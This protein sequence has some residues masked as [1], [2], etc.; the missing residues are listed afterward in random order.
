MA[1][2]LIVADDLTGAL[3]SAVPF[4]NRRGRVLVART[5]A[6][7]PAALASGAEVVS[8]STG[9][10]DGS[11]EA[12]RKALHEV[13]QAIRNEPAILF[14]KIDS[15]LKGHIQAELDTLLHGY[16]AL[17]VSPALPA[18]GRLCIDRRVTGAGVETPIP[19]AERIGRPATIPEI[20]SDADLDAALPGDLAGCVYVGAAGLAAA[21]ARRLRPNRPAPPDL[22][23]PGPALLAI[24][25]RDPVTGAQVAMLRQIPVHDAPNGEA[26]DLPRAP[27][28]L[29]RMT[30]GS[31]PAEPGIAGA[32]FAR[33]AL[34][35]LV[36]LSA[37]TIFAC[38][39]ESAN[40]ILGGMGV[41]HL[42]VLGEIL[43]GVPAATAEY[44][45]QTVTVVTK[46]G[47]FGAADTLVRLVGRIM[48]G[49]PH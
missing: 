22:D 4:A 15:R 3:D 42:T 49:A 10:R 6:G 9:S 47:G 38:G 32:A 45:G 8:V 41:E 25:S 21:L 28:L 1:E 14:K 35:G 24:G 7:L 34:R 48:P 37:R 17:L 26:G 40:A 44:H 12:A 18:L 46:S 20:R 29:L 31:G 23:L 11:E 36:H 39:G 43:P 16:P 27:V 5:P 13:R 19:V 30:Q 33:S 2:V